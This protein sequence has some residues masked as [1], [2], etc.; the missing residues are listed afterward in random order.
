M[1]LIIFAESLQISPNQIKILNLKKKN[2]NNHIIGDSMI[3]HTDK[4]E[5]VKKLKPQK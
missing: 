4:W 3:K 5:I 2:N 1:N